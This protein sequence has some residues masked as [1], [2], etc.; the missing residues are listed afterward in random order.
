MGLLAPQDL[1]RT[2]PTLVLGILEK[3]IFARIAPRI[4]WYVQTS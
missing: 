4:A 2:G 3:H 1:A